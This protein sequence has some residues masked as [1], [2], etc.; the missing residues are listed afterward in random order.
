MGELQRSAGYTLII[1]VLL[2]SMIGT[3]FFFGASIAARFSGAASIFAW[4]LLGVLTIYVSTLFGELV[5]LFPKSGGIYEFAKNTYSRFIGFF[6]GWITWLVASI[7]TSVVI[8]AAMQYILPTTAGSSIGVSAEFVKIIASIAILVLLNYVAYRGIDVSTYVI[9]FFAGI[10]VLLLLILI[11][12]GLG[13]VDSGNFTPL[14]PQGFTPFLFFLTMFFIVESFFGWESATFLGEETKNPEKIIPRSLVIASIITS[15]LAAL[16]GFVILGNIPQ[17]T[18]VN[19]VSPLNALFLLFFPAQYL[20][21]LKVFVA[22]SLIGTASG[23]IIGAPRLIMSLAKDKLF[24]EQ[25]SEIDEKRKTPKKAIIFQTIVSI[26][27]ILVASGNYTLLLSMLVPLALI[28]YV[29]ALFC[30]PALRW[31]HPH[32]ARPFR[33][34][35]AIPGTFIVI[36]IFIGMIFSWLF[37]EP[38]AWALSKLLLSFLSFSIPIYFLLNLYYN[39]NIIVSVADKLSLV[40]LLFESVVVPKPVRK[41]ILREF[42][43]V[44]G[45]TLLDFGAGTGSLTKELSVRVGDGGKIYATDL[46]QSNIAIIDKRM[47]KFGRTNVKAIHDLHQVNRV[48]PDIPLV[49]GIVSVGA[50]SYIQQ[51]EKVVHEF[52]KVLRS[53]GKVVLVDYVDYFFGLIPS[54]RW[55]SEIE[56]TQRLFSKAGL[57]VRIVKQKSL[58]WNYLIITG[59]K[60]SEKTE[61]I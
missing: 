5:S 50:L 48:H 4:I 1:T 46:S 34:P 21:V 45:K 10:T 47:K 27:V 13:T 42:P 33:A 11:V 15:V 30:V 28:M 3:G 38:E 61:Y 35:F 52:A 9:L 12:P 29:F 41:A 23:G 14:T 24:I 26:L 40:N 44:K 58:F 25:F 39:P 54:P 8:I 7:T 59:I 49:D 17:E 37:V 43:D 18:L 19:E 6:A 31:K 2:T 57:Q 51:P 20:V 55:L 16:V 56:E 32:L 36:F 53:Y 60:T 22:L